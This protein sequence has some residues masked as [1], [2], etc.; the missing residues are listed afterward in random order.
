MTRSIEHTA[1]PQEI[2]A[3]TVRRDFPIL[4]QQVHGHRLVYLDNAATTQKPAGAI[5]AIDRYY[6]QDN[7]NVH[8]GVHELSR[9]ATEAYETAR[10]KVARF[11]NAPSPKNVIFTRGTTEA[12]NLVAQ[13]WAR[14]NLTPGDEI[15]ITEMEHHSNIV[16]WQIVCEQTGATLRHLPIDDR[17]ELILDNLPS[18]LTDR[19]RLLAVTHVSNA[20][21]TVNPIGELI[22]KAHAS[23]AL[24]LVDGAQA[25]AHLPVDVQTLDA[26]FY[27]F[28][29]HKTYGPTG[30]GA[31]IARG[32]ILQDMSPYQG[33]GDMIRTVTLKKTTYAQAPAKFEAG[34]PPIAQAVG[35]GA[36]LDYLS[37]LG[38][39]WIQSHE[40]TLLAYA[41]QQL[42]AVEGLRFIG[43]PAKRI[44]A[45]SFI[46]D[47]VHAHDLATIVD[48]QGVAVRAGHHCAQ[49]VMDHFGV[50]ATVRAS[51]G[52][53]ND[54]DDIDNLV[55]ALNHARELFA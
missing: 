17:G 8:R 42:D 52:V 16:P 40:Q 44:G 41:T 28:S 12:I 14:P 13:A 3:Q 29:A 21:G 18:L 36:A 9:R 34:T 46:L 43:E 48:Y 45:V 47:A 24:V 38:W 32:S 19:T 20:L 30:I 2:T 25:A 27:C 10:G 26:D 39:D 5:D 54:K 49:P 55:A 11:F 51:V 23:G 37:H 33:G 4:D 1:N 6:R 53:Y 7:A 35:L 31:L 22:E 50:P 15:L